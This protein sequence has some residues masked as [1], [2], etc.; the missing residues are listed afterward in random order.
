MRQLNSFD[1]LR[2]ELDHFIEIV[3]DKADKE[4][5]GLRNKAEKRM[6]DTDKRLSNILNDGGNFKEEITQDTQVMDKYSHKIFETVE[7]TINQIIK[8]EKI[9]LDSLEKY[10]ETCRSA[11]NEQD[12]ILIKYVKLLKGPKYKGRVKA[13]SKSLLK[14]NGD[15]TK[16]E[17]FIL[18]DYAPYA[19]IERTTKIIKDILEQ[20]TEYE[21]IKDE[22]LSKESLVLE[23]DNELESL[24][25]ELQVQE[26]HPIKEKTNQINEHYQNMQ[27]DIDQKFSNIRKGLR[28]YEK[29]L[30]KGKEKQDTTLMREF[31]TDAAT[32]MASQSTVQ[33]FISMLTGLR[34]N[35]DNQNLGLKK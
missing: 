27:R 31:I 25:Q 32:S 26:H 16:L 20:I 17:R 22:L 12:Q 13:L 6:K 19:D 3:E 15:L 33:P 4:M 29:Y 1:T 34:D 9:N 21:K 11:L 18:E 14:L 2:K 35:L 23:K 8:P 30:S 28:K 10:T 7:S 24:Y 5:S